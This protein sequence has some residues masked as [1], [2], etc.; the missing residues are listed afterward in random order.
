[1]QSEVVK[2]R[3][4]ALSSRMVSFWGG[5]KF[6]S[7]LC[8]TGFL[9]AVSSLLYGNLNVQRYYGFTLQDMVWVFTIALGVLWMVLC[10]IVLEITSKNLDKLESKLN[11]SLCDC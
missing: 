2:K 8:I 11:A 7:V 3:M 5:L 10:F 6:G 4:R 9:I 1:M